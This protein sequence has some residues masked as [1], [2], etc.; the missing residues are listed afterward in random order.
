MAGWLAA[1]PL[2]PLIDLCVCVYPAYL[3][4]KA[5]GTLASLI[6]LSVDLHRSMVSLPHP[7]SVLLVRYH[8]RCRILSVVQVAQAVACGHASL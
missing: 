3:I 1:V 4:T 2:I 6:A 7:P 5:T 8:V